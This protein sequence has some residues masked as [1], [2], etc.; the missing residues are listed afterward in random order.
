MHLI[1]SINLAEDIRKGGM[2][3]GVIIFEEVG[4]EFCRKYSSLYPNHKG[5]L[6]RNLNQKANRMFIWDTFLDTYF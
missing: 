6:N 3:R 1:D 2:D 4:R 5:L